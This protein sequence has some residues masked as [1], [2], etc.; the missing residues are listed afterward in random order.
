MSQN[1]WLSLRSFRKPLSQHL[2]DP[3]M[4]VLARS[5]QEGAVRSI[6]DQSMLERITRTG[7]STT[8]EYEA[9]IRQLTECFAQF[10]LTVPGDGGEQFIGEFA[11]KSSANLGHFLDRHQPIEPCEQ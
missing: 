6:L 3:G 1:F 8:T 5:S 7:W 9:G 11:A 4:Q 2:R 10:A